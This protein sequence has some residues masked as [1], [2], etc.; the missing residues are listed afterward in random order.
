MGINKIFNPLMAD[1]SNMASEPQSYI[2]DILH[3]V[4]IVFNEIGTVASAATIVTITRSGQP[5]FNVNKPFI[6]F[7]HHELS[8]TIL[9]W[10]TVYK[11]TPYYTTAPPNANMHV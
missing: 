3:K 1:L 2:S 7:I 10:G 11:P 9:F 5:A 6:F 4:N 8:D